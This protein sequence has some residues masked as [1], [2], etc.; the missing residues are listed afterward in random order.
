MCRG[1]F[2]D[3]DGT[4]A[5]SLPVLQGVYRSFLG[6]FGIQG[7][8]AEFQKINGP[9]LR[10]VV[11]ILREARALDEP[12]EVLYELYLSL[13]VDAHHAVRPAAGAEAVL[14]LAKQRGWV[15]TVVTSSPSAQ[16]KL[17][18]ER[19]NLHRYVDGVVGGDDVPRGKPAPDPYRLALGRSG[20]RPEVSFAVEDSLQ[21]G[22]SAC[23]AGLPLWFLGAAAPEILVESPLFQ[24]VLPGFSNL[25]NV[26]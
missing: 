25:S 4:L 3:L 13:L 5:D 2:L 6:H 8:D 21:G 17:W 19:E 16:T 15:V 24:G 22:L 14:A 18:L 9:P 20:C 10:Q 12:L 7:N 23:G 26:L 11:S 1:L